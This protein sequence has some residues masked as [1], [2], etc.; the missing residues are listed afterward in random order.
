M[1]NK[2]FFQ[3]LILS[4]V[5]FIMACSENENN[6][7]TS[8]NESY[9]R[10]EITS[11]QA[12]LKSD[13]KYKKK[14][15]KIKSGDK[16]LKDVDGYSFQ[17]VAE[18]RQPETQN[19]YLVDATHVAIHANSAY[20]TYNYPGNIYAGGIHVFDISDPHIPKITSRIMF[21][22]TDINA[23]TYHGDS[24]WVAGSTA[25]YSGYENE[26][27]ESPAII[28]EFRLKK[29][30]F[31]NN[32]VKCD[33]PGFSAN[34]II[35]TGN[36]LLVTSGN[37]YGGMFQISLSKSEYLQIKERYLFDN[38]KYV[39]YNKNMIVRLVSGVNAQLDIFEKKGEKLNFEESIDLGVI[40]PSDGKSVV[41]MDEKYIYIS[42][43]EFGIE[44]YDIK[45]LTKVLE[46]T[47]QL[48]K[49]NTNGVTTDSKFMYI[50][51]GAGGLYLAS[52][53]SKNMNSEILGKIDFKGSA[54]Y[55]ATNK[56]YIFVA[57]GSGGLK[58]FRI[59]NP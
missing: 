54:N 46:F 35:K 59:V 24:L 43:G 12:D 28:E 4:L 21:S 36:S 58:I 2:L 11:D 32:T 52:K 34:S 39:S 17:L 33:I 5:F 56:N 25:T 45:D 15:V 7:I 26:N 31:T 22:D 50:A 30:V 19:G 16:D 18:V 20:V 44:V 48:S 41:H 13:L 55:V 29:G 6:N 37:T 47:T 10:I 53:P 3:I 8:D 9:D 1:K 51:N 40:E 14:E 27:F 57:C 49:G 42:K 23:V 38:S